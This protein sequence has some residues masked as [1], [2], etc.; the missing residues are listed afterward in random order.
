VSK[1]FKLKKWLPLDEAVNHI[2]N[3]LG[4]PITL[5]DIYKCALDGHLIL[6]ANFVNGSQAKEVFLDENGW[7]SESC[8]VKPVKDELFPIKG[9]WD[10]TM[11]GSERADIEHLYHQETSGISVKDHAS[12]GVF[13]QQ[14][15][16]LCQLFTTIKPSS[17][18]KSTSNKRVI[19]RG[20]LALCT[21]YDNFRPKI[22][23]SNGNNNSEDNQSVFHHINHHA[24]GLDEEEHVLVIRTDEVTRFIQTLEDT[25]QEAK[26]LHDK[27]RTTLLVLLGSTLSKANFDL[28]E[29]GVAG[30]IRRATESNN[31]PVAE[32]TIRNLLPQLRDI[33][34]LKQRN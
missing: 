25:P 28:N 16:T 2:S 14:G 4:E 31:T 19:K 33:V 20:L 6:S 7:I 34:E 5:A 3:V 32:E 12:R 11:R 17:E 22:S 30:K 9:L 15:N 1:V 18:E 24:L 26:P 29:R 8:S 10:L 27:E 21:P 23:E 13:L